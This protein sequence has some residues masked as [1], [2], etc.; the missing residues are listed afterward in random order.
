VAIETNDEDPV[1]KGA[2][3]KIKSA[4]DLFKKFRKNLKTEA[5]IKSSQTTESQNM[6][7]PPNDFQKFGERT[8]RKRF[9]SQPPSLSLEDVVGTDKGQ[10][11][12]SSRKDLP[13]NQFRGY[14]KENVKFNTDVDDEEEDNGDEDSE[15]VDEDD[16]DKENVVDKLRTISTSEEQPTTPSSMDLLNATLSNLNMTVDDLKDRKDDLAVPGIEKIF[17]DFQKE[18]DADIVYGEKKALEKVNKDKPKEFIQTDF[19]GGGF[20]RNSQPWG[21]IGLGYGSMGAGLITNRITSTTTRSPSPYFD[22]N[23][24]MIEETVDVL[25]QDNRDLLGDYKV[26]DY[27]DTSYDNP[28]EDYANGEVPVGVKSAL[29]ASSV[30]GGFAVRKVQCFNFMAYQTKLVNEHIFIFFTFLHMYCN[31]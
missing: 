22:L 12:T 24:D 13:L 14:S 9:G 28:Y 17:K 26:L 7:T 15:I 18:K 29:I 11:I 25:S 30:V 6:V 31:L 1:V 20:R 23:G 19:G 10:I 3:G 27:Q 8:T 21:G 5:T 2:D 4:V 16:E